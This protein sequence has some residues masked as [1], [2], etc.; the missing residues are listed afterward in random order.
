MRELFLQ[1]PSLDGAFQDN[2]SASPSA[3]KFSRLRCVLGQFCEMLP[4][5]LGGRD[6]LHLLPVVGEF[7]SAVETDDVGSGQRG[8]LG[9]VR[10][11]TY[12]NRKAITGVF[13]AE[14]SIDQFCKHDP[15]ST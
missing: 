15:P 5:A 8:G 9:A 13:A 12:C 7:L 4:V 3:G 14:H 2:P 11:V 6:N 1:R 10:S